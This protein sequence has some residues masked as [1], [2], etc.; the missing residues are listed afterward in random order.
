MSKSAGNV[1]L[2]EEIIKQGYSAEAIRYQLLSTHYRQTLNFTFDDLNASQANINKIQ[3][4][5]DSL[6]DVQMEGESNYQELSNENRDK[7]RDALC[8]DL[9]TSEALGVTFNFISEV[10]K[11]LAKG[12]VTA[13]D[14]GLFLN[15]FIDFNKIFEVLKFTKETIPKEILEIAEQRKTA[16][17]TKD[18][19]TS[20]KLR[21]ELKVKGY[22]V[23]DKSDGSYKLKRN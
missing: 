23:K 2:I 19:A 1:Y 14:A 6:L 13:I 20:D 3:D 4:V 17:E 7:F 21:E 22:M 10:N 15:Y 5:V 16:K 9:N 8:D 12:T 18:F 11:L